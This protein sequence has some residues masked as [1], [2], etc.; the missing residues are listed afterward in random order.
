VLPVPMPGGGFTVCVCSG[1]DGPAVALPMPMPGGGFTVLLA[2]S[3]SLPG[4]GSPAPV[5]S[6]L[7]RVL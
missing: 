5:M 1:C 7:G 6:P 4:C 2:L 3:R